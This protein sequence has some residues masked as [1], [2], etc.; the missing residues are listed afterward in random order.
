MI[1][2]PGFEFLIILKILMIVRFHSF[3]DQFCLLMAAQQILVSAVRQSTFCALLASP[4]TPGLPH[5]RLPA[6]VAKRLKKT[7]QHFPV[8]DDEPSVPDDE[9]S[10]SGHSMGNQKLKAKQHVPNSEQ[11][12]P[13]FFDC[14]DVSDSESVD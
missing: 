11:G 4:M 13:I 12:M 9:P 14:V 1:P 5:Q 3:G 7:P 6:P 2:Y 10:V 8:P